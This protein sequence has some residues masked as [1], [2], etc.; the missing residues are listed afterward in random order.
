MTRNKVIREVA[1]VYLPEEADNIKV[2]SNSKAREIFPG[3]AVYKFLCHP[4][5]RRIYSAINMVNNRCFTPFSMTIVNVIP[6]PH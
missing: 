3:F 6:L 5:G 4:E 2:Q 1:R